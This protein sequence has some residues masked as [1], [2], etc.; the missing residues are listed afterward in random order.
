MIT[1]EEI[2]ARI[3]SQLEGAKATAEDIGGGNHWRARIVATAFEGKNLVER[4]QMIY[5]I[6][7]DKMLPADESIHAL[8]M[9][10]LTPE[11]DGA[12]Q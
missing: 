9:K 7:K 11:E 12:Q 5:A 1:A 3:E 6:F 2:V 10:T 4:H 8:T